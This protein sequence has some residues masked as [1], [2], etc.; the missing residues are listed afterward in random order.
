MKA[1]ENIEKKL[2]GVSILVA[3]KNQEKGIAE[4]VQACLE[5][6]YPKEKLEVIAVDDDSS[7][8]TKKVL[9]SFGSSV[10]VCSEGFGR[11]G[12][13]NSAFEKARF[14]FVCVSAGDIIFARD[15]LKT[16]M[17]FFTQEN[18]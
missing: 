6:D 14:D 17:K 4:C 10:K 9:E 15:F 18:I 5:L 1:K 2:P 8:G 16:I 12:K 13:L 7:D 11:I 3:T